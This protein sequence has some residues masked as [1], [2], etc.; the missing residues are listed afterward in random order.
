RP[1]NEQRLPDD[2]IPAYETP[3]AAIVAVVTIVTH[4]EVMVWR[5]N[6]GTVVV[7][8]FQFLRSPWVRRVSSG[9]H[10]NLVRFIELL[11]IDGYIF[12]ANLNR[13]ARQ[14]NHA[15]DERNVP[16]RRRFESNDIQS[17]H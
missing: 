2:F 7:P 8:Y 14:T 6:H 9:I 3:I 1:I 15:F 10:M 13:I 5:D 11:P 17:L 16:V 4:H 12:I